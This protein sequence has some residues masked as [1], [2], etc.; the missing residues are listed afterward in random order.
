MIAHRLS[1]LRDATRIIVIDKGKVAE[2][3]WLLISQI[4]VQCSVMRMFWIP[5]PSSRFPQGTLANGERHLCELG[6]VTTIRRGSSWYCNRWRRSYLSVAS[7][8]AIGV[9]VFL[10]LPYL[11]FPVQL[12][13]HSVASNFL[14]EMKIRLRESCPAWSPSI[15]VCLSFNVLFV[16][17]NINR[18]NT[19]SFPFYQY[20]SAT[21]EWGETYCCPN[22][23]FEVMS[24]CFFVP[25]Y[26]L[27]QQ[28][29]QG[30]LPWSLCVSSCSFSEYN[31]FTNKV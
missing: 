1:S 23:P 16:K 21:C 19:S 4:F 15:C 26:I 27:S 17:V 30:S 5:I 6:E 24:L 9:F 31:A 8:R 7:F 28:A 20:S 13:W 25:F 12:Y 29:C 14:T 18:K 11:S 10:S 3:G 22:I 2:I